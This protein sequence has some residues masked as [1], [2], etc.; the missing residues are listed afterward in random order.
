MILVDDGRNP[1]LGLELGGYSQQLLIEVGLQ[2]AML[3]VAHLDALTDHAAQ[4]SLI[5]LEFHLL[6]HMMLLGHLEL[7]QCLGTH[8]AQFAVI[9]ELQML[10]LLHNMLGI[11]IGEILCRLDLFVL[12]LQLIFRILCVGG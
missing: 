3:H 5:A 6:H 2:L 1:I 7:G 8:L 11:H 4:L 9:L 10:H 12:L